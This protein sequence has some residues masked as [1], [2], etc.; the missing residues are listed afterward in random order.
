MTILVNESAKKNPFIMLESLIQIG[1][2][3]SLSNVAYYDDEGKGQW[4]HSKHPHHAPQ[5][6]YTPKEIS[7]SLETSLGVPSLIHHHSEPI[8]GL[9]HN[10][11]SE[12]AKLLS[13]VEMIELL[14][15]A[16]AGSIFAQRRLAEL[17]AS[18]FVLL[19]RA[20]KTFKPLQKL[21]EEEK[22]VAL[23]AYAKTKEVS[24][25]STESYEISLKKLI[26]A[27]DKKQKDLSDTLGR[28]AK[29]VY[30]EQQQEYKAGAAVRKLLSEGP[31]LN[32][33]IKANDREG[34][35]SAMEKMLP[36][37]IMEPTEKVFW[38]D[39]VDAIRK[40]NYENAEVMFRGIDANEKFQALKDA[41]GNVI[42]GGNA[43]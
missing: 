34:V 26:D 18:N 38:Q 7:Y 28:K 10:V 21:S 5:Y 33:M 1:K 29:Q 4:V 16:K 9:D 22:K 41:A 17:D 6:V 30:K 2:M 37:S 12:S 11:I 35:A 25:S 23:I 20:L 39:F 31:A 13:P 32:E 36:W 24:L 42:G 8:H 14:T 40:P 43:L 15:N 19:K 27:V 3:Y